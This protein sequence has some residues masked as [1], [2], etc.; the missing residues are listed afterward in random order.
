M[1]KET[2]LSLSDVLPNLIDKGLVDTDIT[3]KEKIKQHKQKA[4]KSTTKPKASGHNSSSKKDCYEPLLC[5]KC[6]TI[7][8]HL[9][10]KDKYVCQKCSP[11]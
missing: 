1:T 10:I 9:F 3:I 11:S 4:Q 8:N 6:G 7:T 5:K 2:Y